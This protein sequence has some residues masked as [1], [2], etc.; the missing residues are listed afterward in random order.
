MKKNVTDFVK[1][2]GQQKNLSPSQEIKP[3][4]Y[5]FNASMPNL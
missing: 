4:T 3:Q 5:R 2:V 1:N